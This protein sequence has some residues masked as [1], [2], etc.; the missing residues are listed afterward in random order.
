M[1]VLPF[2]MFFLKRMILG[3]IKRVFFLGDFIFRIWQKIILNKPFN[4]S[5]KVQT[6]NIFGGFWCP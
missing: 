5:K 3:M 1:Y 6:Y 4:V 2:A